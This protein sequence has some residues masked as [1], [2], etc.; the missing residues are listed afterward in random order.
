MQTIDGTRLFAVD[1]P[2][3]TP[4]RDDRPLHPQS[5]QWGAWLLAHVK[6][7]GGYFNVGQC[8]M[9]VYWAAPGAPTVQVKLSPKQYQDAAINKSWEQVPWD[10]S[11]TP[12]NC[13]DLNLAILQP[14]SD[15]TITMWEFWHFRQGTWTKNTDPT[16]GAVTWTHTASV[17]GTLTA[18][19]GGTTED[20]QNDRG[21]ASPLQW[22][23]DPSD[24]VFT[25]RKAAW[26]MNV[27]ATGVATLAGT[28][29]HDDCAAGVIEHALG[30]ALGDALKGYL[31]PAQR[32]DGGL[33]AADAMPEGAWTRIDPN[34]DLDAWW[35]AHPE[36]PELPR[37]VSYAHQK[38]GAMPRDRTWSSVVFYGN[39]VLPGDPNPYKAKLIRPDNGVAMP[40]YTAFGAPGGKV[41]GIYPWHAVIVCDAAPFKTS[42]SGSGNR[43]VNTLTIA[44]DEPPTEGG[45]IALDTRNSVL[46]FP[47]T[48][49]DVSVDGVSVPW[50]G[51]IDIPEIAAPTPG[52][53]SITVTV[54]T[55]GLSSPPPTVSATVAI[56]VIDTTPNPEPPET[57]AP[58]AVPSNTGYY[59]SS[60]GPLLNAIRD[61]GVYAYHRNVGAAATLRATF[62]DTSRQAVQ[63]SRIT[64]NIVS[65]GKLSIRIQVLKADGTVV[66]NTDAPYGVTSSVALDLPTNLTPADV[67][68][69][70]IKAVGIGQTG[71]SYTT[72]QAKLS[73]L[74]LHLT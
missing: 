7:V 43:P 32:S 29:T 10:P 15:G 11:M 68:G 5:A 50:T 27:T 47:R 36:A 18:D 72:D 71:W 39:E 46:E 64:C 26:N 59:S 57:L 51:R 61:S 34:F 70:Y 14:Q 28:V 41:P 16:T 60:G 25:A 22:T 2:W 6:A 24:P 8:A 23:G 73:A 63:T 56:N 67:N 55:R 19:Y 49:V 74:R 31:Y 35:A 37:M 12:A 58:D 66:A 69:L 42:V 44:I 62:L 30:I 1:S 33:T 53:H 48:A 52:D 4:L 45:T 21:I 13:N 17:N 40:A 20:V 65:I 38:Y 9:P 3:N 54:T